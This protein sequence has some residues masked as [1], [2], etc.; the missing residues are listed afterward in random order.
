ML[1]VIYPGCYGM[2]WPDPTRIFKSI[3]IFNLVLINN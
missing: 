3:R 1:I 2:N